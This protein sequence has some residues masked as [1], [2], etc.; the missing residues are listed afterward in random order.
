M[1]PPFQLFVI[2]S[3][4]GVLS[5]C[6][7][8][9]VKFEK[10]H[11]RR[12]ELEEKFMS[13]LIDLKKQEELL[14]KAAEAMKQE[15]TKKQDENEIDYKSRIADIEKE[16]L[17]TKKDHEKLLEKHEAYMRT[18]DRPRTWTETFQKYTGDAF[19]RLIYNAICGAIVVLVPLL[20]RPLQR[21]WL[22]R[23]RDET[24]SIDE[25]PVDDPSTSVVADKKNN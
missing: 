9:D 1:H 25:V 5:E 23:N 2:L 18:L 14:L 16:L 7:K 24:L 11:H 8:P 10:D 21:R 22:L 20:L 4:F 17:A 13:N 19:G 6:C 12:K 3:I 15:N